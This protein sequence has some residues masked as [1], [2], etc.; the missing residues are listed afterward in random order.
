MDTMIA[1]MGLLMLV[2][3]I[4]SVCGLVALTQIGELKRQLAHLQRQLKAAP[5]AMGAAAAKETPPQTPPE[6]ATAAKDSA[7][8]AT[9]G[10]TASAAESAAAKTAQ[11]TASITTK[12]P[13]KAM[14]KPSAATTLE[15]AATSV[16]TPAAEPQEASYQDANDSILPP[17]DPATPGLWQRFTA[18]FKEHWMVWIGA[19]A[20][21]FGGIF[22][23]SYSLE[24]GLLSVTARLVLGAAFGLLLLVGAEYVHRKFYRDSEAQYAMI[25]YVPAALAAGGYI[26]L[27]ALTALALVSYKLLSPGSAFVMLT[28]VSVAASWTALRYGPLLAIIGMLGAYS[29]PL[30][31]STGSSNYLELVIFLSVLTLNLTFVVRK[32]R[33]MWL[34]YS[35]WALH[36]LWLLLIAVDIPREHAMAMVVFV[37]ISVVLLIMIPRLGFSFSQLEHRVWSFKSLVLQKPDHALLLVIFGATVLFSSGQEMAVL[38]VQF[39]LLSA[40]FAVAAL[41]NTRWQLWPILS[42]VLLALLLDQPYPMN[43]DLNHDGLLMFHGALGQAQIAMVAFLVYGS[44]FASRSPRHM[45][46]SFIAGGAVLVPLV[47]A[48]LALPQVWLDDVKWF[49]VIELLLAG[50]FLVFLANRTRNK[51]QQM[52]Y[53]C[54]INA[55]LAFAA[56]L[57]LGTHAL[58]LALALQVVLMTYLSKRFAQPIPSWLLKALVTVVAGRLTILWIDPSYG[59]GLSEPSLWLYPSV[60]ALFTLGY[61][62]FASEGLKPWLLGVIL[63]VLALWVSALTSYALVGHTI[64]LEDLS[65]LE[66]LVLSINWGLLGCVYLYRAKAAQTMAQYYTIGAYLLLGAA[67]LL[68]SQLWLEYNPW[69]DRVPMGESLLSSYAWL[70]YF[71]PAGIGA[72]L[73]YQL[74]QSQASLSRVLFGATGFYLFVGINALVRQYW[75]GPIIA[76]SMGVE[77]AELYSYSVIWLLLGAAL[78]AVSLT[79]NKLLIQRVGVALLALVIAKVFLVD[80]ANLTGL[81]RALSFIGL[82]LALVGLGALFKWLQRQHMPSEQTSG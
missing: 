80:M 15:P 6:S 18:Q 50:A 47:L 54:A 44:V 40:L 19:L 28:L 4:G 30:W 46:F 38:S 39:W 10:E 43:V 74:R 75:Q 71:A 21:A 22:F 16:A 13:A 77:D 37:P 23:V 53:W 29:V 79:L 51:A 41:L 78:V 55:H 26:S 11:S 72:W 58:T 25:A 32:V 59:N 1:F 14:A 33:R 20:L 81:L 65:L 2:V 57:V 68:Q 60:A 52:I 63:H 27:F 64:H 36:L 70:Y 69:F 76:L 67:A 49:W 62:F 42:A 24:A 3:V 9:A 5:G 17:K 31:V 82:G 48:Y 61:R 12:P 73:G 34:W 56:T 66:K 45:G 35:I 8:S 7:A